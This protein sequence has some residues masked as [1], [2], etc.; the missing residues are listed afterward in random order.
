MTIAQDTTELLREYQATRSPAIREK[1]VLDSVSL[2]HFILGRLGMSVEMGADYEDLVNQGLLALVESVDRFDVSFGTQF[3]T[4]ATLRI[5]GKVIDYLRSLDWL[6]RGARHRARS[7]QGAIQHLYEKN[8]VT[9]T[10]QEVASY[11]GIEQE[12]V[13]RA[14]VDANRVIL[15]LDSLQEASSEGE[16]SAYETVEDT[17]QPDPAQVIL[18]RDQK[19]ELLDAIQALPERERLVLSLYYYEEMT[20]KEIGQVLNISESRVC[21]LHARAMLTLK[22]RMKPTDIPTQETGR[23]NNKQNRPDPHT[24]TKDPREDPGSGTPGA[25]SPPRRLI[26]V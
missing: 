17:N 12:Q 18:E 5:R 22:A 7:V 1:L 19:Q 24:L 11:L 26:H 14:L 23:S 21:Q 13:E 16:I 2:V 10:D 9:P 15:S 6:S 8:Q 20:L 25:H 3:S 4:Y